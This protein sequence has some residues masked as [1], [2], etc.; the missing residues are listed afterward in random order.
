[1]QSEK[2]MESSKKDTEFS[3]QAMQFIC[4]IVWLYYLYTVVQPIL[5]TNALL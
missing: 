3:S 2:D 1:M 4:A 5:D